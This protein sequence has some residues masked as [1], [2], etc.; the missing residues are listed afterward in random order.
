M[1][2]LEPRKDCPYLYNYLVEREEVV[3][4]H[5][6]IPYYRDIMANVA[7]ADGDVI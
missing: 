2:R 7:V 3:K 6:E 5:S 4:I 1:G